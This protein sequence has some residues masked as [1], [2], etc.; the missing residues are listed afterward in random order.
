M[1]LIYNAHLEIYSQLQLPL[2]KNGVQRAYNVMCKD[3]LRLH[4]VKKEQG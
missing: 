1:V 4:C 3:R 2:G